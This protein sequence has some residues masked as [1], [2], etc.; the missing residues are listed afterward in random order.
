MTEFIRNYN[1]SQL[2][3]INRPLTQK[4]ADIAPRPFVLTTFSGGYLFP[5]F[6]FVFAKRPP[7]LIGSPL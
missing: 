3:G 6:P 2:I 4:A 5:D 7:I 1:G